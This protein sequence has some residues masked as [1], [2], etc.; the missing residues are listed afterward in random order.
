[1]VRVLEDQA[2]RESV[3]D[4][5]EDW[6]SLQQLLRRP[7]LLN[8]ATAEDMAVFPFLTALHIEQFVM[9]RKHLGPFSALEELQAVPAWEPGLIRKILP[10]VAV[11]PPG[12]LSKKLKDDLRKADHQ[13]LVRGSSQSALLLR[14]RLNAPMIGANLTLE[15]DRGEQWWQGNKGIAFAS[16]HIVVKN[17]GLVRQCVVGDYLVNLG[18]GFLLWQGRGLYKSSMAVM[19]K[20]QQALLVPYRSSDENRFMRGSA[21]WLGKRQ[22]QAMAYVSRHRLDANFVK[23]SSNGSGWVTAFQTSGLHRTEAERADRD[24]LAW[25]SMG[26]A[27][28]YT[29]K[30]WSVGIH[31]VRHQFSMPIQR[32][33][34][35]YNLFAF[36]GR[37]LN[38]VGGSGSFSWRG[39]HAFGEIAWDGNRFAGIGGVMVAADRNLDFSV[40]LRAAD[41]AYH[42]FGA[43]A[44]MENETVN[45]EKG[46]YLGVS[47][48]PNPFITVDGYIDRFQFP[49]LRFRVNE[50][51]QGMDQM[52]QITWKPDRQTRVLVRW[53]GLERTENESGIAVFRKSLSTFRSGFRFHI[54]Q[55]V[56]RQWEWRGRIEL[57]QLLRM[58]NFRERG[59]MSYLEC[60][61]LSKKG[62]WAGNGRLSFF[63][64]PSYD[65]RIYAYEP[66]VM[67]Y[68]TIPANFGK[69]MQLFFNLRMA[70]NDKLNIYLKCSKALKE[71]IAS[72]YIRGQLTLFF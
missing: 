17:L 26:G 37:T 28:K 5:E 41:R 29:Q 3:N 66:D 18:Q 10:Y 49:W 61:W 69:G 16:A 46:V 47:W 59:F 31:G 72:S 12:T 62:K 39:V 71:G 13:V 6:Q 64:T 63:D 67:Y 57:S 38:G 7:L 42:A 60:H 51:T 52:V 30:R 68:S 32:R 20:K 15:K 70:V 22:W 48:R 36:S 58:D 34:E 55:I 2:D 14:Y 11:E 53:R 27:V 21:I 8:E 1:M 4:T 25:T 65:T 19:T 40:L 24:A 56:S 54:E 50:P 35:P 45:N 9:Y 33:Q 44:F 43:S 23:D